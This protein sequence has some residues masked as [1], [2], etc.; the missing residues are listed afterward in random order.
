[1]TESKGKTAQLA[2]SAEL[3]PCEESGSGWKIQYYLGKHI[4]PFYDPVP[5]FNGGLMPDEQV[6]SYIA[7]RRTDELK[8]F[9]DAVHLD[10]ATPHEAID[11]DLEVN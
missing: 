1:M 7:S 11:L 5:I 8:K 6:V 10:V 9:F 4:I 3:L 2:I